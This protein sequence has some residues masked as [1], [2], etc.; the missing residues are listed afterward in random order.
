MKEKAIVNLTPHA[1]RIVTAAGDVVV[2]PSGNVARV[3]QEFVKAGELGGVR[4]VV[5]S[6]GSV[7]GLP[8]YDVGTKKIYLVS[9]MVRSAVPRR[10]DVASPADFIR[11]EQGRIV[12]C[13]ALEVNA[14]WN[15]DLLS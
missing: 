2:P 7:E 8:E 3:S 15:M 12:A 5:G 9:A 14:A 6:Y 11:D 4:I 1:V 10:R 13:R